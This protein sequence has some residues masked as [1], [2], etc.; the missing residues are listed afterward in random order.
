[1]QE[2]WAMKSRQVLVATITL[3]LIFIFLNASALQ[4]A[5]WKGASDEVNGVLVVKN[6]L[7]PCYEG[8][9]VIIKHELS[10]G[11]ATAEQEYTF[12]VISGLSIDSKENIYVLDYK[13]AQI[14]V[15]DNCGKYLK[16][17][18]RKGQGPGEMTSPYAI[19]ISN[20]DEIM[21]QDLNNH[22][23][24]FF[25]VNGDLTREISTAQLL[26]VGSA[27]DTEGNIIGLVSRRGPEG[28]KI[29]L[30]KYNSRLNELCS[31]L[32]ISHPIGRGRYN[33]FKPEI[34]WNLTNRD[35]MFCGY[36]DKYEVNV[37]SPA[38]ALARKILKEFRPIVIAQNEVE[39]VKKRLPSPMDMDIPK[40]HSAYQHIS[41]DEKG[42]LFIQTW[43]RK[44]KTDFYYDVFDLEG[45]F[46]T[47]V[48]L[49]SQP[50]MW[51][52]N[53]LYTIEEDEDGYQYVKRY[54]VTWNY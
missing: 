25:T 6:P 29:E 35:F 1:M 36:P 44:G 7:E 26:M 22:R 16:T 45:K 12:S 27:I 52:K 30:K 37:F 40:Y 33:P 32:S 51:K 53:K 5:N 54:K 11:K 49:K 19:S 10:I 48:I 42:R 9:V 18:G 8:E 20:D 39:E 15:F 38:G 4:K 17:I 24:I 14:K 3:F 50:K 23:L 41:V 47:K 31:F 43:E 28:Q 34:C 46:I 21:V 13:D 2:G